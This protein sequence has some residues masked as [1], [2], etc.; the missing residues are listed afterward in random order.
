MTFD[1]SC[2]AIARRVS[3]RLSTE[4]LS[5]ITAERAW[6]EPILTDPARLR[7]GSLFPVARLSE[8]LKA[9]HRERIFG[10]TL[11]VNFY[12]GLW[13]LYARSLLRELA[14]ISAQVTDAVVINVSPDGDWH[15]VNAARFTSP[16]S[17][18]AWDP[19]SE[20]GRALGLSYPVHPYLQS[21]LESLGVD[22]ADRNGTPRREVPLPATYIVGPSGLIDSIAVSTDYTEA[23]QLAAL[24]RV[25]QTLSQ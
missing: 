12:F 4:A 6:L 23:E 10:Q 13:S 2:R 25:R 7:L 18:M 16:T 8:L 9:Q 20:L 19:E 15:H 17:L 5:L 21:I 24:E 3:R 1:E 22:L 14:R 11:V